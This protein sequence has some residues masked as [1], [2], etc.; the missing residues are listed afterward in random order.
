[1]KLRKIYFFRLEDRL[2]E[3][4]DQQKKEQQRASIRARM[5]EEKKHDLEEQEHKKQEQ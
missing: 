4:R 5:V 2:R 1:M 3:L